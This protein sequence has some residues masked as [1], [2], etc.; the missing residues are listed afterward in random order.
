MFL[1]QTAGT[2]VNWSSKG[3]SDFSIYVHGVAKKEEFSWDKLEL[4][5]NYWAR[6]LRPVQVQG[7]LT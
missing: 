6:P 1:G 2:S 5:I 4:D 3:N 7:V